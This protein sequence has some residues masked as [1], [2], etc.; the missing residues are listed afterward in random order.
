MA[1]VINSIKVTCPRCHAQAIVTSWSCGCKTVKV[2]K[3]NKKDHRCVDFSS[4]ASSCG[5]PG[6]P[7]GAHT[8]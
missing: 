4:Y 6:S 8:T 1:K 2:P 5:K 7:N 3:V